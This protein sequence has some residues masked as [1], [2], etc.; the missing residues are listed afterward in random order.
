MPELL[1]IF[2]VGLDDP[3]IFRNRDDQHFSGRGTS[4]YSTVTGVEFDSRLQ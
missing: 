1:K 3:L 2:C 4:I